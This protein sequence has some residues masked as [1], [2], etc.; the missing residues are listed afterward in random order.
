MDAW[1]AARPPT[2]QP[3][4]FGCRAPSP[5]S[6]QLHAPLTGHQRLG[7]RPP[8]PPP[9][10]CRP[11][12]CSVPRAT[13]RGSHEEKRRMESCIRISLSEYIDLDQSQRF[14]HSGRNEIWREPFP[15]ARTRDTGPPPRNC[16]VGRLGVTVIWAASES[17]TRSTW[18]SIPRPD[19]VRG[20]IQVG[21][22]PTCSPKTKTRHKPAD[23]PTA[24]PS[25]DQN[26]PP[27][28]GSQVQNWW[29]SKKKILY[30]CKVQISL[31]PRLQ[32]ART[33]G[34]RAGPAQSSAT[35]KIVL[36]I[37]FASPL[38]RRTRKGQPCDKRIGFSD[39]L[40]GPGSVVLTRTVS[41][42]RQLLLSLAGTRVSGRAA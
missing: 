30:H 32:N 33:G 20:V 28:H 26:S 22:G 18:R 34:S 31:V 11:R 9:G 7:G 13:R 3:C 12:F 10:Q 38:P 4:Q 40:L 24:T 23:P 36:K 37:S 19:A 21:T 41:F 17:A 1:L 14:D 8:P 35:R 42:S 6:S 5:G 16:D 27:P 2:T 25:M 15:P 39:I 29:P